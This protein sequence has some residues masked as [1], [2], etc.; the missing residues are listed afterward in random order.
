MILSLDYFEELKTAKI[1]FQDFSSRSF[2]TCFVDNNQML[3]E[4]RANIEPRIQFQL[5][6]HLASTNVKFIFTS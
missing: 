6:F 5:E 2:S 1:N 4:L 3:F